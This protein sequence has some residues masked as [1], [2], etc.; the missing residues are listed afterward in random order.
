MTNYSDWTAEG[1]LRYSHI[2]RATVLA[3]RERC[4]NIAENFIRKSLADQY[5]V[6]ENE[7]AISISAEILKEPA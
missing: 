4:A 6:D 7:L 2:I 5:Y 1:S 3:E